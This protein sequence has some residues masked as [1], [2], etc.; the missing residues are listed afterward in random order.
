[1]VRRAR[2]ALWR[3]CNQAREGLSNPQ[4][5][6][7]TILRLE[8]QGSRNDGAPPGTSHR[9]TPRQNFLPQKRQR[10]RNGASV[11][12]GSPVVKARPPENGGQTFLA[13]GSPPPPSSA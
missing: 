6:E 10:P 11:A 5:S 1:M 13:P 4:V 2:S 12:M 7:S 9:Q 8:T 3:Q